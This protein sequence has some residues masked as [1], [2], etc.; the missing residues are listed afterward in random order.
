MASTSNAAESQ[1]HNKGIADTIILSEYGTK[2]T[3]EEVSVYIGDGI[4]KNIPVIITDKQKFI[5]NGDVD[6]HLI[7]ADGWCMYYSILEAFRIDPTP[8]E[9]ACL[10]EYL[11]KKIEEK[12]N[13][14]QEL[15]DTIMSTVTDKIINP[16]DPSENNVGIFTEATVLPK[17]TDSYI[18]YGGKRRTFVRT[19][20][21]FLKGLYTPLNAVPG[22]PQTAS[23]PYIWPV[24]GMFREV[25]GD[26]IGP[27][28]VYSYSYKIPGKQTSPK[29]ELSLIESQSMI[30]PS[31]NHIAILNTGGH[32]ELLVPTAGKYTET[33][34]APIR[35][36]DD[37]PDQFKAMFNKCR[38]QQQ[39]VSVEKQQA[40]VEQHQP[41][42]EQQPTKS[43]KQ[44]EKEA[45][46]NTLRVYNGAL[47]QLL[48]TYAEN[49]TLENKSNLHMVYNNVIYIYA[50]S[51]YRSELRLELPPN[52]IS[53]DID[54]LETLRVTY[55]QYLQGECK[56]IHRLD[57]LLY[58]AEINGLFNKKIG[59]DKK[60]VAPFE[61]G[62]KLEDL[63]LAN[64]HG[65][66]NGII[67]TMVDSTCEAIKENS[68][69]ATSPTVESVFNA[70]IA[71]TTNND[72]L[73]KGADK[74]S[75]LLTATEEA[76]ERLTSSTSASIT[77]ATPD[78][79][80]ADA[81]AT[82]TRLLNDASGALGNLI[83]IETEIEEVEKSLWE[84]LKDKGIEKGSA[85]YNIIKNG[86]IGFGEGAGKIGR[87]GM[88]AARQGMDVV[89]QGLGAARQG[90]DVVG[91]GL[92]A[93]GQGLVTAGKGLG[94]LTID[95][96]N[97]LATGLSTT[98]QAIAPYAQSVGSAL[99][100][101]ALTAGTVGANWVT[102]A[103]LGIISRIKNVP[104]D[105]KILLTKLHNATLVARMEIMARD[106]TKRVDGLEKQIEALKKEIIRLT[107]SVV[108]RSAVAAAPLPNFSRKI[109]EKLTSYNRIYKIPISTPTPTDVSDAPID[110]SDAPIDPKAMPGWA[111]NLFT[112]EK[113]QACLGS[114]FMPNGC[115]NEVMFQHLKAADSVKN[116][117]RFE[118]SAA[119]KRFEELQEKLRTE[120]DDNKRKAL[121]KE[122]TEN[123]PDRTVQ[124]VTKGGPQMLRVPNPYRAHKYRTVSF[125]APS[126]TDDPDT[127]S[128]RSMNLAITDTKLFPGE[129][130]ADKAMTVSLLRSLWSCNGTAT[131]PDC[132]PLQVLGELYE[133]KEFEKQ[134]AV[135]GYAQKLLN[136]DVWSTIDM[137]AVSLKDALPIATF[138]PSANPVAATTPVTST[139]S[140][141]AENAGSTTA[142]PSKTAADAGS[143]SGSGSNAGT[144]ADAARTAAT[145]TNAPPPGLQTKIHIG[146]TNMRH[147]ILPQYG[148][149]KFVSLIPERGSN[150][151]K[152]T[153]LK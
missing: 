95:L 115:E 94:N 56:I 49:N 83:A 2:A 32:F 91:Q 5:V 42:V 10:A 124:I 102:S 14:N 75:G 37:A 20:E 84:Y 80:L 86:V 92:G 146:G 21:E 145:I 73:E 62:D 9:A 33:Y 100:N 106:T 61:K 89:G 59:K 90:M 55:I 31:A 27:F 28:L 13:S 144:S 53:N 71:A 45:E 104:T 15:K 111:K 7:G 127:T 68:S 85:L 63:M 40:L 34:I 129:V 125:G 117:K 130:L 148:S 138:D 98:G 36:L 107:P 128:M 152:N 141:A 48:N 43:E 123:Y 110:V 64:F 134:K 126:G 131:S 105:T 149:N 88:G 81:A 25:I 54:I 47:Q 26:L 67:P 119:M 116:S 17:S 108:E 44:I 139:P 76:H 11:V 29:S 1:Q 4:F 109:Q 135:K 147:Y 113:A 6:R 151:D 87:Q 97:A 120:Q 140:N 50:N 150:N 96:S 99:G 18:P 153:L 65:I 78:Q 52:F 79:T 137:I 30:D 136:T 12:A 133:N 24:I 93:A 3:G 38:P 114:S 72:S 39:Q 66:N 103:I 51:T 35:T 121:K 77:T 22:Q 8:Q 41:S 132:F 60:L 57:V 58:V 74:A 122:I 101:A 23:G 142:T 118:N 82:V 70:A 19:F 143:G 112:H 69:S 46:L 16:L